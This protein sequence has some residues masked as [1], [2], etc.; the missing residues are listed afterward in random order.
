MRSPRGFPPV[1]AP[2]LD[3]VF[4]V[5]QA[6][7]PNGFHVLYSQRREKKTDVGDLVRDLMLAEDVARDDAGLPRLAHVRNALW[8]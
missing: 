1:R 4:L 5:V 2:Y 3:G 7:T 8:Q 6:Q